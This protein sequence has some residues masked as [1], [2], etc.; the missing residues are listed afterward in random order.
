MRY[1]LFLVV[2]EAEEIPA[3]LNDAH[4]KTGMA[5]VTSLEVKELDELPPRKEP[6]YMMTFLVVYPA[7][8]TPS[9]TPPSEG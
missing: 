7:T 5:V 2:G 6:R 1:D 9:P 3:Q 4:Q 8:W